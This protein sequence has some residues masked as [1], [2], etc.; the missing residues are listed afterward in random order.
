MSK[1]SK[2]L[3]AVALA[4]VSAAAIASTPSNPRTRTPM[5]E[6]ALIFHAGRDVDPAVLPRRNAAARDWAIAL[7]NEGTLRTAAPLEEEGFLISQQGV[8]P[9]AQN[10]AIGGVVIVSARDLAA[11]VA[12]AK[13]HPGLAFGTRVE[14]R[15]VKPVVPAGPPAPAPAPAR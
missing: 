5:N 6:F 2:G 8:T 13:G 10:G 9:V 14:V 3:T 11:A 15:P 1:L 4:L 7:R 12:L